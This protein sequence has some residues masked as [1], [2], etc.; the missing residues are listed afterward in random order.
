MIAAMKSS[1]VRKA[2]PSIVTATSMVFGLISIVCAASGHFEW[3]AWLIVYSG[4][5]DKVDGS[6]AR[7]LGVGSDFGMHMDSFSDFL[8]FGV[9]P[10]ALTWFV[11]QHAGLD[12]WL[13][14]WA[15]IA[16]VTMPL[17]AAIR[18]ARFNT[19]AHEDPDCFTGI[20]TTFAAG[21]FA[22]FFLSVIDL[23]LPVE[24][25]FLL[26]SLAIG[27]AVLMVCGM[28]IPKLKGRRSRFG[29][30]AQGVAVIILVVLAVLRMLPEVHFGAGVLYLVVGSFRSRAR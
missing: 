28:R 27:F 9:A 7:A 15:G 25:A 3:A 24:P 10:G 12:T 5:L 18:L 1:P 29:N 21:L 14:A 8:A 2:A 23:G 17:A 19:I 20:P 26:P 22:T 16:A 6:L 11:A 30:A 4:I 13:L